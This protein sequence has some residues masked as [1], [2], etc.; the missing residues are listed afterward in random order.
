MHIDSM[1]EAVQI[2]EQISTLN[3]RIYEF[4]SRM[5]ELNS[6]VSS[7]KAS[8]NQQSPALQIEAYNKL[9]PSTCSQS[10]KDCPL[11]NEVGLALIIFLT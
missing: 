10:N 3:E 2:S 4:C 11:M 5:E 1:Q 8:L 9:T 6:T 7:Q